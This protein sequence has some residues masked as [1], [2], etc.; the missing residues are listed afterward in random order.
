MKILIIFIF[1]YLYISFETYSQWE[2][3]YARE[4]SRE[5]ADISVVFPDTTNNVF[6]R[7]HPDI[8]QIWVSYRDGNPMHVLPLTEL[9][10]IGH[11]KGQLYDLEYEGDAY[12]LAQ[13]Y[14]RINF[15]TPRIDIKPLRSEKDTCERYDILDAYISRDS[16][17]FEYKQRCLLVD[18]EEINTDRI[19]GWPAQ[20]IGNIKKLSIELESAFA[21]VENKLNIDSAIVFTGKV[22]KKGLMHELGLEVGKPSAFSDLIQDYILKSEYGG[23]RKW[24]PAVLFTSGQNVICQIRIYARLNKDGSIHLSTTPKL[25][26]FLTS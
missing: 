21:K 24:K 22:D 19:I 9:Y 14:G 6:F 20:W 17:L 25:F 8:K 7:D 26:R 5:K 15:V 10:R 4:V 2:S 16:I 1:F 12:V 18:V 11:I 13:K 23:L 3:I